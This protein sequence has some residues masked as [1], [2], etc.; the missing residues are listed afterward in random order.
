[1]NSSKTDLSD[2][3]LCSLNSHETNFNLMLCYI[4]MKEID[5]SFDKV[6]ELI[7]ARQSKYHKSFYLI[8]GLLF[9]S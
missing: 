5:K 1:M 4:L 3:G 8:R 9:E 7:N 2:V 6:N